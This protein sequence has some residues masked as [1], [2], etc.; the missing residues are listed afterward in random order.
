MTGQIGCLHFDGTAD[1]RWSVPALQVGGLPIALIN[2]ANSAELMLDAARHRRDSTLPAL[3]FSS[4]N[5]QVL[6]MSARHSWVRE[7]FLAADL[8]HADGM[9]LVFVS[10][11]F[12][13]PAL[14]ERVCTTDLF[15]DV[16][17]MAPA[18]RARMF[19]LGA[20]QK[21]I[22]EAVRRIRRL[23][24]DLDVVGHASGYLRRTEDEA[25]VI[26]RINAARPDILWLG[27]GVPDEQAFAVRNRSRLRVGLIKTSGGLFDYISGKN[28]RAPAWMR[29]A[30]L[31]WAFRTY[32]EPRRLA[33]RYL[34]TNPHALF[35]LLTRTTIGARIP[36]SNEWKADR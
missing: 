6:S 11:L 16:A 15:H 29:R 21:V 31:E 14:P 8:I 25:R 28:A 19:L 12:H 26:E 18:S 33:G 27:L 2:R 10:R 13:K 5:G 34:A 24:P 1:R 30:G 32:L 4:A 35:L 23:Y 17:R 20:T 36:T 7:L 9:P 3:I 22:D